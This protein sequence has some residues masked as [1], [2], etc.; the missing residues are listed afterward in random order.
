MSV[1]TAASQQ[2]IVVSMC[3]EFINVTRTMLEEWQSFEETGTSPALLAYQIAKCEGFLNTFPDFLEHGK[4]L[5]AL[6]DQI[7]EKENRIKITY[8]IGIRIEQYV[9]QTVMNE[10]R[11][12]FR[13]ATLQL[14]AARL[15]PKVRPFLTG[16][17]DKVW[18][19][20]M[21]YCHF[22]TGMLLVFYRLLDPDARIRPDLV[23]RFEMSPCHISYT[24]KVFS[25]ALRQLSPRYLTDIEI[26]Q[27]LASEEAED[28]TVP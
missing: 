28:S 23:Y 19:P 8:G 22:E 9:D 21:H 6:L 20:P 2:Q 7:E 1:S 24:R 14:L 27:E 4:K 18:I 5:L 25:D 15:W 13:K 12:P 10:T 26:W 3:Q 17:Y 11:K 16:N